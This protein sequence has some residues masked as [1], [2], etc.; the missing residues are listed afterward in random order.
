MKIKK[1]LFNFLIFFALTFVV[2]TIVNFL[3][4]LIFH[5]MAT[6]S[7]ETSFRFG[8]ILGILFAWMQE[9]K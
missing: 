8:I 5:G 7:W 4:N 6:V 9:R 3:W 2:S 1:I